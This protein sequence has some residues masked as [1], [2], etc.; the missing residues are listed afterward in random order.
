[1]QYIFLP[2]NMRGVSARLA[3]IAAFVFMGLWHNLSAG[4]LVWGFAHG[5]LLA[6]WPKKV[7]G[8]FGKLA[9]RAITWIAVISLSYLAN[10]SWLA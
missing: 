5:F 8:S 2:L 1:M 10:Y 3:T 7:E 9:A 6:F 4:Y